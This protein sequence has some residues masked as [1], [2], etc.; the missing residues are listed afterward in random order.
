MQICYVYVSMCSSRCVGVCQCVHPGVAGA[1]SLCVCVSVLNQ[2]WQAHIHYIC[3]YVSEFNQVWQ[4]SVCGRC[5]FF[6]CVSV[7]STRCGRCLFIRCACV[8]VFNQVQQMF[9]H[10]MESK[11]QYH[12]PERFWSVFRLWG[13][14]INVR[15]Q[16]DA[17]D[18]FQAFTDQIDEH[19][20][21]SC[22][23]CYFS[24]RAWHLIRSL[25]KP[26]CNLLSMKGL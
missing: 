16:Q 4:V 19:M 26:C 5:L 22:W 21:V 1:Y 23:L 8:S 3:V 18:F 17:F 11:L 25:V 15:E 6:R 7:C 24:A 20:K 12:E 9:G 2:V 10:L 13:Q 14:T